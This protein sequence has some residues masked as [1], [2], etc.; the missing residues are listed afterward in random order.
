MYLK[1][2][3]INCHLLCLH[4]GNQGQ[5]AGLTTPGAG[6]WNAKMEG[7]QEG[8][9]WSVASDTADYVLQPHTG[10]HSHKELEETV[11]MMGDRDWNL[12]GS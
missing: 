6:P 1:S 9:A 12:R 8:R 11:H 5:G 3:C 7:I 10:K 4:L 2:Y